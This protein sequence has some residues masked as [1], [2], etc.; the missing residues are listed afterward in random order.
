MSPMRLDR[1]VPM[2]KLLEEVSKGGLEDGGITDE[3][4][5]TEAIGDYGAGG[6]RRT[7][8]GR[9]SEDSGRQLSPDQ[10]G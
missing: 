10:S 4:E 2:E 1:N 6:F 8:E 9:R 5:G 3:R 7:E